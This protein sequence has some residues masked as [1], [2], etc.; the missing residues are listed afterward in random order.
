MQRRGSQNAA[1]RKNIDFGRSNLWRPIVVARTGGSKW[2]RA[3]PGDSNRVQ[4]QPARQIVELH[5][6]V[7]GNADQQSAENSADSKNPAA[8]IYGGWFRVLPRGSQWVQAQP[9]RRRS[10]R[11]DVSRSTTESGNYVSFSY[12]VTW[13]GVLFGR[14]REGLFSEKPPLDR[15]LNRFNQNLRTAR[16][17]WGKISKIRWVCKCPSQAGEEASYVPDLI[18]R[19]PGFAPQHTK[20]GY[21]HGTS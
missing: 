14:A 9:A 10:V 16:G 5:C 18:P 17:N 1:Q 20:G 13:I 7:V 3:L 11:R 8:S 19:R 15:P 6:P 21:I 2:N 12:F 4:A